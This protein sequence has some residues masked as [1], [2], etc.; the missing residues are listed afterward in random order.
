LRDAVA[1]P[2]PGDKAGQIV[3][4]RAVGA[5]I[6]LIEQALDPTTE[7]NLIRMI[8]GA[9]RPTHLAMPAAAKNYHPEAGQT[10]G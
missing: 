10:G 4:I 8:L 1:G 6:L 2:I 3:A 9:D 7:A 5:K